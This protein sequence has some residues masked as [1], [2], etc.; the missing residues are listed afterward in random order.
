MHRPYVSKKLKSYVGSDVIDVINS[1]AAELG[2]EPKDV[3][4]EFY[5]NIDGT[6]IEV[7]CIGN[8]LR[9]GAPNEKSEL[10]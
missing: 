8:D 6:T 10:A 2:L 3:T 1:A 5:D 7:L 9:E 4:V